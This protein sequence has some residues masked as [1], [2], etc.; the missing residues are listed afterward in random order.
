MAMQT[1]PDVKMLDA[2]A[3]VGELFGLEQATALELWRSD[4]CVTV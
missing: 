2:A 3:Q 4:H 1:L